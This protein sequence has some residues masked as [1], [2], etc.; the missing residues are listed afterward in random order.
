MSQTSLM[1]I[2]SSPIERGNVATTSR[3]KKNGLVPSYGN[4]EG[5]YIIGPK[6]WCCKLNGNYV[7]CQQRIPWELSDKGDLNCWP[8]VPKTWT[9]TA[10]GI[11]YSGI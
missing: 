4:R 7:G 10:H 3:S 8:H 2:L 6:E 11:G 1:P 5:E 9:G